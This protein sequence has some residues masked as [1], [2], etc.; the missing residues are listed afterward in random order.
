MRYL[1]I[2]LK[3]LTVILGGITLICILLALVPEP[4]DRSFFSRVWSNLFIVIFF[5]YDLSILRGIEISVIVLDASKKTFILVFLTVMLSIILSI[6]AALKSS[7]N[8]G[9]PIFNIVMN[10]VRIIS[11]I[12]VLI[13]ATVLLFL[14]FIF[15]GVVPIYADLESDLLGVKILVILLPVTALTLGD[16]MIIDMYNRI[17]HDTLVLMQ[18]P[19]IKGLKARGVSIRYHIARGMVLPVFNSVS[20][21]ITFLISGAIIVEYIFSWQ[22]LGFLIWQAMITPGIK[23]YPL[24]LACTKM[25]LL[26]VFIISVSREFLEYSL[27][28]QIHTQTS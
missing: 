24:I 2:L 12:P 26:L 9:G 20:S 27:K 21:K 18:Q 23:D 1:I 5:D 13:W 7:M 19:W 25:L 22:G 10:T 11:T 4:G 28:P 8:M 3:N 6:P 14:A 16:G 15:F 17:K